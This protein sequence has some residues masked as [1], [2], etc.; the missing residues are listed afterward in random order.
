MGLKSLNYYVDHQWREPFN[1]KYPTGGDNRDPAVIDQSGFNWEDPRIEFFHKNLGT[2]ISALFSS[3]KSWLG[4]PLTP[5]KQ[6]EF[7][8]FVLA[9][10]S[11]FNTDLFP[12]IRWLSPWDEPNLKSFTYDEYSAL[13][14]EVATR[15]KAPDNPRTVRNTNIL[16][17]SSSGFKS[18][19]SGK[20][21]IGI[22]WAEKLYAEYDALVDGIAFDLWD[23]RDLIESGE[24]RDAVLLAEDIM[25]KNDTDGNTAE[26]IVINQTSM[27]SG[28]G[29]SAYDVN[30]H[31]GA[32]WLT[33]AVC[34]AFASGR[35][36]AFHYFTA[37][38][39]ERHMKGLIYSDKLPPALPYQA[40]KK[41][42]EVKPI[43]HA[44]AMITR[45]VLDEVVVL[46]SD[47]PEVDALLTVSNDRLSA[48]LIVVNK[49][50]RVNSLKITADLPQNMRNILLQGAGYFYDASMSAPIP[51][52][53]CPQVAVSDRTFIFQRD[54]NPETVYVFTFKNSNR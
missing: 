23:R 49:S 18:I 30:T 46:D 52:P 41:P 8:E 34:N 3:E 12:V 26:Q 44:M 7:A 42:Y 20:D 9:Y 51:I 19:N 10:I 14:K 32:L 37:I 48:G 28:R 36:N 40:V 29:S 31:F 1:G 22:N 11:H 54:L 16:A 5:D 38:D 4:V 45:T 15:L 27:S 50:P 53:D 6:K 21:R 43:G 2:G 24:F 17:I 13:L 35:L 47:S 39:D 33:G 25:K